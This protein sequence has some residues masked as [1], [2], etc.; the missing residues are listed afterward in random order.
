MDSK[1]TQN[2]TLSVDTIQITRQPV[3]C[4]SGITRTTMADRHHMSTLTPSVDTIHTTGQPVSYSLGRTRPT[5][6]DPLNMSS[7]TP[8][9]ATTLTTGQPACCST[10][11]TRMADSLYMSTTRTTVS[12]A[13]R[14]SPESLDADAKSKKIAFGGQ[15]SGP[16]KFHFNTGVAVSA[17]NEIFVT[18]LHNKRV[19]IFTIDGAFLRNFSTIVPGEEGTMMCPYDIAIDGKANLWVVGNVVDLGPLRIRPYVVKYSQDGLP[20]TKFDIPAT[21]IQGPKRPTIT[22]DTR[23]D[24]IIVVY[25]DTVFTYVPDKG[26]FHQNFTKRQPLG[27]LVSY[28]TLDLA[29]N[30]LLTHDRPWDYGSVHVYSRNGQMLF[31]FSTKGGPRGICVDPTTG[32]ILVANWKK[33]RVVMFT[34]SGKFVRTVVKASRPDGIA[35]GPDGHLVVNTAKVPGIGDHTV[36]VF[37]RHMVFGY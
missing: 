26:Y 20:V 33:D 2:P 23:W 30:I 13:S 29:G 27:Y 17:N 7:P 15:G 22:V 21:S 9:A 35:L 18:D 31:E 12:P 34:S 11:T 4:S 5:K 8:F 24:K 37:P 32:N 28:V 16:G 6:A 19:Q 10:E 3:C 14:S 36:I 25:K 1:D